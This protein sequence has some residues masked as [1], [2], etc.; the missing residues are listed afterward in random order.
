MRL[1]V[2]FC[3]DQSTAKL[4]SMRRDR[5]RRANHGRHYPTQVIGVLL[6]GHLYD[7]MNGLYNIHHHGGRT[8]VQ[9]PSDAEAPD[10]PLNALRRLRPNYVLP[11]SEI[12]NAIAKELEQSTEVEVRRQ[13]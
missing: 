2:L 12:P 11:L 6:T 3:G 4:L 1:G 13:S 7:G 9:D 5:L 10:I 8:I